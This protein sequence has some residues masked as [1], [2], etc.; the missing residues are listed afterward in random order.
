M[1]NKKGFSSLADT[2][3]IQVYGVDGLLSGVLTAK[4]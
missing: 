1:K 2:F 3:Y 4:K